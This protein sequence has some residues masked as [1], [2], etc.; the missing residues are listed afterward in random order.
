MNIYCSMRPQLL[1]R[2]HSKLYTLVSPR[3]ISSKIGLGTATCKKTRDAVTLHND[4]GKIAWQELS[5]KEKVARSTKQTFNFSI[6]VIGATLSAAVS[7]ILYTEVFSSESPTSYFNEAFDRVIKD[8]RCIQ[9]L[10]DPGEVSAYG[11]N[12]NNSRRRSQPYVSTLRTDKHKIK[13]LLLHFTVKGPKSSGIVYV[14]MIKRP[15]E[16]SFDYQ[17]LALDVMGKNRIYLENANKKLQSPATKA[18]KLFG[19]TWR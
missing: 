11:E 8:P 1:S 15:T 6:I 9:L 12:V 14:H 3:L 16:K 10:G 7:Y 4:N 2:S 17:Y 13:H 5:I 19:I 18:L